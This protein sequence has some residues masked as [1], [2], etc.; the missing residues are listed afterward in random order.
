MGR[1]GK[2]LELNI[3]INQHL[4]IMIFRYIK[5]MTYVQSSKMYFPIVTINGSSL[6]HYERF[7]QK[8]KRGDPRLARK[9]DITN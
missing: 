5:I 7:F 6:K 4:Y 3:M 1:A 9:Y 2:Y 8:N